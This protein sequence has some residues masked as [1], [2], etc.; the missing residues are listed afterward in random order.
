MPTSTSAGFIVA[1]PVASAPG[2]APFPVSRSE[3][4][5]LTPVSRSAALASAALLLT[6]VSACSSERDTGNG[7]PPGAEATGA[8]TMNPAD[9]LVGIAMPT[10]SLERWNKDGA[11]LEG[12]LKE[13][14]YKTNLQYAGNEVDK[15]I[16][17]LQNVINGGANILVVAAIDGTA[18]A[19]ILAV[20]KTQDVTIIAYDRLINE[21]P[22]VDYYATFDNYLVGQLQGQFI[23]DK[24]GLADGAGP[25]NLEPFAGSPDDNNAKFFFSGAWDVL[26]PYVEAGQLVVPSGKSPASN[27]DWASIGI[28]GWTSEA[29]QNEMTNR[30]NSFYAAGTKLDVVLS[31]NDSLALGDAQREG[32]VR[33][34]H[35]I[36]LRAGGVEGVEPVGHLV[37]GGL[38]G[39]SLDA[40][41]RPVLVA[42]R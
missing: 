16:S 12:L 39:P 1:A 20:A 18:L 5:A 21:T 15:Q 40:D 33:G 19:P 32:V 14:G 27:E 2:G 7:A 36:Q 6:G 17:Q 9:V 35:D 13:A 3:E 23:E 34:E 26:L 4:H 42:G 41:A 29:A 25:F 10:R 11:N 24:L 22:D 8:A 30:L 38:R 37:L 28:Q 31:P